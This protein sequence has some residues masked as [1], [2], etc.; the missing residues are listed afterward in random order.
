MKNTTKLLLLLLSLLLCFGMLTACNNNGDEKETLPNGEETTQADDT[1]GKYDENGYLKDSLPETYDF[2][3]EYTVF[4]WD[5]Q[6]EWEWCEELSGESTSLENVLY[7]RIAN[8]E[9]RFGVTFSFVWETGIWESRNSFIAT[10]SNSVLGGDGEFDLV[11]Q[12]TP[13]S[14]IGAVN[15]LYK[16]LNTVNYL[17]LEKPWWPTSITETA[18]VGEKLYFVTGDITP[19]L[20]RNVNCAVVNLDL[21]ESY[22]LSSAIGG[23][24]IYQLVDDYEWTLENMLKLALDK[25]SVETGDYGITL[26][27]T[28]CGDGFFYGGGFITVKNVNGSMTLSDDL[29]SQLL[30]DYFDKVKDI[31]TGRYADV[32]ITGIE[33]FYQQKSIFYIGGVSDSTQFAQQGINF[34]LLPMPLLNSEDRQEYSVISSFY[35][36][37]FSIPVDVKNTDMSSLILEALGSEAYRTVSD[38]VY[39]NLFQKR[40]NGASEDSAR[41]F[42][43]VSESVVFD[44]SRFFCDELGL[45]QQ[46]RNGVS[47]TEGNWSTIYASNKD[48]WIQRLNNLAGKVG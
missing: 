24:S 42:D 19:T 9:E 23:R 44:T 31:M 39:Y 29:S 5:G 35:V 4:S 25:V 6:D 28:D 32:A 45:F 48:T 46:F 10:L 30:I 41:M 7:E 37:M 38:E 15:G 3:S 34:T 20:I 21:F 47:N 27:N 18:T 22:N 36:S 13:C 43:L 8:V 11:S 12:Y 1:D 26:R 2:K 16:D 33:P 14:G 40:Y 17:D